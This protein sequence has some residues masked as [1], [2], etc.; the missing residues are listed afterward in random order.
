MDTPYRECTAAIIA[1]HTP[2]GT[3]SEDLVPT[4]RRQLPIHDLAESLQML[5]G[6]LED[7][8]VLDTPRELCWEL[9]SGSWKLFFP[10]QSSCILYLRLLG[11]VKPGL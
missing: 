4:D 6:L 9:L 8:G 7:D 11:R 10:F 1:P 5:F 3:W 2:A